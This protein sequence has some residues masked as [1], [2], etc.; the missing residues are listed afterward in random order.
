MTDARQDLYENIM[1]AL[2]GDGMDVGEVKER[3]YV[4]LGGYEVQSR[5]TEVA[6]LSEDRNEFLIRKFMIGKTVK[7]CTKR[8]LNYYESLLRF[9]LPRIGKT[10]DDITAD[11]YFRL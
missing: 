5:T 3:I 7:G 11:V 1:M 10:V 6:L 8:T 4:I 9:I 2:I